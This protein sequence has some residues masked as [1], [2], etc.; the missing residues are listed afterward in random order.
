[1]MK[2]STQFDQET[3]EEVITSPVEE[4][5]SEVVEKPVEKASANEQLFNVLKEDGH[6]DGDYSAF[7]SQFSTPETQNQLFNVL[8]EDGHN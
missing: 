3:D 1:M 6:Y 5:T 4:V 8:K 7:N 2:F